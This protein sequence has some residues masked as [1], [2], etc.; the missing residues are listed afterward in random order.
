M[1]EPRL[2]PLVRGL[3]A[4]S[5]L[6]DLASE[7]MYPL[8][9]ALLTRGLG[10]GALALGALDGIADAVSSVIKVGAGW[11]SDRP[12][13]RRPLVLWGYAVAAVTRPV[14]G[15]AG[16]AWQ[17]VALR[18]A[19]RV[20]KGARTPPRDALIAD[21][22]DAAWRGRAFGFHRAMDHAGAMVGPLVATGLIAG[23]AF[24]PREVILWSAVPG[25]LGV[26]VAGWVLRG[27][28]R[29][30]K[31]RSGTKADEGDEAPEPA[32]NRPRGLVVLVLL[33]AFL[34][35]PEALLLLRLQDVGVSLALVPLLWSA[36]HV[37][38]SAA[39]Y[40]GGWLADRVGPARTMVLGWAIYA[41]VCVGLAAA[42]GPAGAALWFLLFGLVA[43]TTEAPER[44]LVAAWGGRHA[45]GRR[46]GLYHA[47]LGLVALPGGLALGALYQIR[48]GPWALRASAGAALAVTLAGLWHQAR[49]RAAAA[50]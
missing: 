10:A 33:F 3:G 22:V 20:G 23:L 8:L 5:L 50:S 28:K 18:A 2:P 15:W 13:W 6:N 47:G 40:P 31:G 25:G 44:A 9:P 41:L 48:G 39:S 27:A 12:G 38:R 1:R 34:R 30:E 24:T 21:A 26:V 7:M 42:A 11:L 46:F 36:L 17:V 29:G 14:M 35:L 49:A 16:A 4:V 37:V 45:R 43:A 32:A 19:D